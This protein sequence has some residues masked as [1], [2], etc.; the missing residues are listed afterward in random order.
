MKIFIKLVCV[1]LVLGLAGPFIMR[2]PNGE[3][4]LDY[5]NFV[6]NLSSLK[7]RWDSVELPSLDGDNGSGEVSDSRDINTWGKTRVFRWQDE[8]GVWQYSDSPPPDTDAE[9]MWF[10]PNENIV[11]GQSVETVEEEA[12]TETENDAQAPGFELPLPLTVAPSE[13]SK[14]IEDTK[15]VQE[16]MQQRNEM[17]ESTGGESR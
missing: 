2:A 11:L 9:V 12:E 15:Q 5:R 1:I 6:P 4:Y 10:D 16:L 3:P 7:S 17:L 8:E 13:V 14:L